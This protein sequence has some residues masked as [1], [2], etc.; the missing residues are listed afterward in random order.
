MISH[1]F[2]IVLHPLFLLLTKICDSF[3]DYRSYYLFYRPSLSVALCPMLWRI[4][5]LG[6]PVVQSAWWDLTLRYALSL[7][8]VV[9]V[10]DELNRLGMQNWPVWFCQL[11]WKGGAWCPTNVVSVCGRCS[12][13]SK[14]TE[15]ERQSER[16]SAR[17]VRVNIYSYLSR[18]SAIARFA[19]SLRWKY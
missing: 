14:I 4:T 3:G 19:D 1:I 16:E 2:V 6:R 8:A 17:A 13:C 10:S 18:S 9:V 15:K 12:N 11:V 7:P 5:W